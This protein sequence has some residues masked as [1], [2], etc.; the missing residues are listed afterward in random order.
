MSTADRPTSEPGGCECIECGAIFIGGPGHD[1][2]GNCVAEL[3]KEWGLPGAIP[4]VPE[5]T[6]GDIWENA[7]RKIGV[8][9]ACEWFGYHATHEFTVETIQV[10]RDRS[11][12]AAKATGDAS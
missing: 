10:L 9:S 12:F 4:P 8:H 6:T 1:Y 7:I 2:C 5:R 11:A 3:P